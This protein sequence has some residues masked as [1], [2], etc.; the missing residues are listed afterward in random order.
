[1]SATV[2]VDGG[3]SHIRMRVST[4]SQS[5]SAPGASHLGSD[6]AAAVVDAVD[7][8]WGSRTTRLDRLVAGLTTIPGTEAERGDLAARLAEVTGARE[9]WVCGDQVTSH[10]GAF[11]GG[12]GV[13]LSVGTGI[14]CLAMD[15]TNGNH[16]TFDGSGYLV[17]DEG[18]GFWL[19]RHGIRAALA[20]D[21]GRGP[22]TSLASAL[23]AELGPLDTASA[24][25]HASPR[26]VDTI[27]QIAVVV[28]A[29][30][31]AGDMVADAIVSDAANRLVTT[32]TAAVSFLSPTQPVTVAI[33]GRLILE[34]NRLAGRFLAEMGVRHPTTPLLRAQ[35]SSLDGACR[36]ADGADPD[37]Y[38]PLIT[39]YGTSR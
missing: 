35:G 18:G 14:A 38:R 11:H 13:L 25:L 8:M 7:R 37:T 20:A 33:D 39:T 31:E 17:G 10:A 12:T 30:A 23:A 32:I 5:D 29:E 26:A 34:D 21:E 9:V 2:G 27:A 28:L 19:G 6:T 3:Q 16:R 36:I 24:R 4:E 15:H 1:M 22:D